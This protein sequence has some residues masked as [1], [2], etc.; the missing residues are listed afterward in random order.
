MRTR[1]KLDHGEFL[2]MR[3]ILGREAH[4]RTKPKPGP[5]TKHQ[6]LPQ[7]PEEQQLDVPHGLADDLDSLPED[8]ICGNINLLG[9]DLFRVEGR[10]SRSRIRA[11]SKP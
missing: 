9:R 4:L 3:R 1:G 10:R 8:R 6:G 7:I 11:S 2:Y 5:S